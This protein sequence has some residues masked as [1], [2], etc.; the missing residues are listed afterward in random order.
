MIR[1]RLNWRE[2]ATRLAAKLMERLA[3]LAIMPVIKH[4]EIVLDDT[5]AAE[6]PQL[7]QLYNLIPTLLRESGISYRSIRVFRDRIEVDDRKPARLSA[8][9]QLFICPHC[10]FVTPYEEEYWNHVKIHYIGF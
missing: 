2:N 10:G 1:I 4:S 6:K 7:N 3:P 8:E 5:S 9:P